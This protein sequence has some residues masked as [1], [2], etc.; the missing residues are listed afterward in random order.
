MKVPFN[1]PR[2]DR[3]ELAYIRQAHTDRNFLQ[4][5]RCFVWG[6]KG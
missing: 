2:M 1:K 3:K 4:A 6:V 5:G